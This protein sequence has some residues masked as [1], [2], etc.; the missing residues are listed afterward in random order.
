MSQVAIS[1][2]FEYQSPLPSSKYHLKETNIIIRPGYRLDEITIKDFENCVIK[3]EVSGNHTFDLKLAE[4]GYTLIYDIR[5]AFFKGEEVSVEMSSVKGKEGG[6]GSYSFSFSISNNNERQE[7]L[8]FN[9]SLNRC[10]DTIPEDFVPLFVNTFGETQDGYLF[11]STN[12]NSPYHNIILCEDGSPLKYELINGFT[13][14]FK[15]Q[16]DLYVHSRVLLFNNQFIGQNEYFENV[17][18]F[19]CQN[20]YTTDFHD[21][22][23]KEDGNVLLISYDQQTIDMSQYVPGGFETAQVTGCVLQEVDPDNNVVFQWR[24]WD[25]YSILDGVHHDGYNLVFTS[26]TLRYVHANSIDYTPD[27]NILLSARNMDEVTKIDRSSGEIIWRLGGKNNEFSFVNDQFGKFS[28]QHDARM[29]P[30]GNLTMLDNGIQ[31]F[32]PT[33]RAVEY[34][35]D[36][37]NKTATVVWEYVQPY[38]DLSHVSG[39]VQRLENG[40]SLIGWGNTFGGYSLGASEVDSTE[41]A[42]MELWFNDFNASIFSYRI[43]KFDVD[44]SMLTGNPDIPVD[45]T[46]ANGKVKL[47]GNPVQDNLEILLEGEF[48]EEIIFTVYDVSGKQIANKRI[49]NPVKNMIIRE[50][51]RKINPGIYIY[52][53]NDGGRIYS[54]K[55]IKQ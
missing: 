27:G 24:S 32:N 50:D 39:N 22:Q 33:S 19:N 34:A 12:H 18:T 14:D 42:V 7:D 20:G 5:R 21:I 52:R 31:H 26:Q 44:T 37:V 1:Q 36:D 16:N 4:N 10:D 35:I 51:M 29:L 2:Y 3:G 9:E 49:L 40:N 48:N 55:I 11:L 28:G 25:H 30:N 54:G 8:Y 43:Y 23:L 53:I 6:S 38:D 45:K 46:G 41:T 15:K 47:L 13:A 17:D